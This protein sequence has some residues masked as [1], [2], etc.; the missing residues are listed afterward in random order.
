MS[1]FHFDTKTVDRVD[2][3]SQ[4]DFHTEYY[5]PQLPLV[6]KDWAKHWPAHEKWTFDH[7]KEKAG[8]LE[9]P[10]YDNRKVTARYSYNE[11]H[12]HMSL[13]EYLEILEQG[14]TNY[15]IF[16][17][18]LMKEVP[19]LKADYDHPDDLGIKF[20]EKLPFLF[21]GG[22]RSSVLMH[23]DIDF[24]NIF[25]VHFKGKKRCLLFPPSET[26]YLY[27]LPNSLKTHE[28]VD[29]LNPDLER[30]PALKQAKGY[31]VELKPGETL[32]MPEGYWHFMYYETAGFSMSLRA[33]PRSAF[34]LAQAAYNIAIMR[35][36][37]T[38]MRKLIGDQWIDWQKR[39]AIERTEKSLERNQ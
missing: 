14:P 2:R 16:L 4:A 21:F 35:H 10:L 8:H 19:S 23:Y 20:L 22:A 39:K 5:Q 6:I 12:H 15:R 29:F 1:F 37:E 7:F 9:V 18:N 13:R 3:I 11:P 38:L 26:P 24:A 32:Y 36:T 28:A 31:E 17:F 33:L 25:H 30:F 27:K 34:R